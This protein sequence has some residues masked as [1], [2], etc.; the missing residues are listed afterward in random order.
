MSYPLGLD[1]SF[2]KL[3]NEFDG[4]PTVLAS[5]AS[6]LVKTAESLEDR[7]SVV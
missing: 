1:L 5:G 4:S 3:S 2:A 6:T 7:K